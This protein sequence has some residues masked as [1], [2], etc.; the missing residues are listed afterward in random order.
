M[1]MVFIS[2]QTLALPHRQLRQVTTLY[3][4]Q[5]GGK[6]KEKAHHRVVFL[7]NDMVVVSRVVLKLNVC[8]LTARKIYK[9]YYT[10]ARR[11]GFYVL[12]TRT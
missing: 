8:G 1:A 12:A 9:G 10:V 3:E 5:H 7:F 11:Y 6:K 4:I 2:L